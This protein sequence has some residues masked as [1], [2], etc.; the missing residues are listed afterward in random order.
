M[1][2]EAGHH[3]LTLACGSQVCGQAG[4]AEEDERSLD[5]RALCGSHSRAPHDAF[6]LRS[7]QPCI[8]T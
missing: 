6:A 1:P 8:L 3:V 5:T 7:H 2:F 4:A